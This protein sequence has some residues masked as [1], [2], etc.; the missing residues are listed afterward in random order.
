MREGL[1]FR[2]LFI[3]E[4]DRLTENKKEVA[5]TLSSG[6]DSSAVLF[7]LLEL[8]KKV[9]AYCFHVEGIDSQDYVHAKKNSK[10][11]GIEFVE[12]IIPKKVDAE[13]VKY[14]IDITGR[15]KKVEVECFYPYFFLLPEIEQDTLLLGL[16]SDLYF[17]LS[18]KGMIH[19]KHTIPKLKEFRDNLIKVTRNDVKTLN[20]LC[21]ELN[22]DI[23]VKDP[24]EQESIFNYFYDKAWDEINKP[25]QKQTILSAFPEYFEKIKVFQ[26][27]NL[28]CGD[29]GIRDIFTPLLNDKKLNYKNRSRVIDLYKDIYNGIQSN[30]AKLEI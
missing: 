15:H 24:F 6:I 21:E 13:L 29:S 22:Y 1:D 5:I 4:V 25:K 19:Y 20:D 23:T 9:T 14:F 27:T 12:C 16:A 3:K 2:N 18:K 28:Q 7:A 17:C 11:F 26:H 30:Y 10:T 8:K